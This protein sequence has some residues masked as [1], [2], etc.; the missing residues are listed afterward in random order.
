MTLRNSDLQSVSDLDSI[1]NSCDVYIFNMKTNHKTFALA[2]VPAITQNLD[3][4][5][6]D[7]FESVSLEINTD[8]EIFNPPFKKTVVLPKLE[9]GSEGGV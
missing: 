1:R 6:E 7:V 3:T 5:F 4:A 9:I 2:S 8:R